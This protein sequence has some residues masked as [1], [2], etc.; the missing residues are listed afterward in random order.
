MAIMNKRDQFLYAGRGPID[1]KSL[2]KTYDQLVD[3][4]TWTAQ[5]D[6]VD[7]VVAYNGM[8]VA[9]WLDKTDISKNGLYFL[10]DPL[11]TTAV[12]KPDVTNE[13]NWHKLAD[14][15]GLSAFIER[16]NNIESDLADLDLRLSTLEE[17]P[18]VLTYG[19][20]SGFPT[21]GEH[22]KLYVAVDTGK[23]YIWVNDDYLPV[24][25]ETE[26]PDLI[27]GGSAN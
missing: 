18:D 24:S 27:Y 5:I 20:R 6:G 2:V 13:A 7:T 17:D 3:I 25:A 15:T 22:N 9:V 23:S 19:Y 14:M 1:A 10:F 8:L 11:V 16:L 12:K 21:V 4:T 26:H